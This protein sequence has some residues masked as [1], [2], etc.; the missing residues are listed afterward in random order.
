MPKVVYSASRGLYQ[1]SGSGFEIGDVAIAEAAETVSAAGAVSS[2]GST[3]LDS[4][5]GVMANTLA[6]NTNVGASK[7][8][9]MSADGG[10]ATLTVTGGGI[11]SDGTLLST[12]TFDDV[13][14][15]A[16]LISDGAQWICT[17]STATEA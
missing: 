6:A 3:T 1:E 16:V 17:S 8:I 12:I 5:A 7:F 11:Q 13:G 10:A 9:T 14:D 4:T 2:F 15:F